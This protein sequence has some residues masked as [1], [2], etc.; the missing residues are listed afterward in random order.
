M[1]DPLDYETLNTDFDF[2]ANLALFDK[3]VFFNFFK[4]FLFLFSRHSPNKSI[5]SPLG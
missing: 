1:G 4:V 3:A 2:A 5:M